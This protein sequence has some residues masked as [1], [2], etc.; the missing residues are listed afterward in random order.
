MYAK[1]YELFLKINDARKITGLNK[2]C[3]ENCMKM[4][5]NCVFYHIEPNDSC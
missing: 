1:V 3:G 2:S 4:I 5:V